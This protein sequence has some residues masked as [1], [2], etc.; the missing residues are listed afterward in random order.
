[1]K[2]AL[3]GA[4]GFVGSALLKEALDRGH[5]VTAIVRHPE[6][7]E[8]REGLTAKRLPGAGTIKAI[9]ARSRWPAVLLGKDMAVNPVEYLLHA[10]AACL[11]QAK[12]AFEAANASFGG[13]D[14]LVNNA[15]YSYVCPVE[16]TPLADFRAQIETD[17]IW[18]HHPWPNA[19][20]HLNRAASMWLPTAVSRATLTCRESLSVAG[21]D[22]GANIAVVCSTF[23]QG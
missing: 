10:L 19:P 4:T 5:V 20:P 13:L 21:S 6:K 12:A 3:L 7:F 11:T 16:D 1:M 14:V 15:G 8:K 9:C 18:C 2:V 23:L 22:P 17:L